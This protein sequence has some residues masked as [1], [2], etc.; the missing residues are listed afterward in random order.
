MDDNI[1]YRMLNFLDYKNLEEN[2]KI[3]AKKPK[4]KNK[5]IKEALMNAGPHIQNGNIKESEW[6]ST[7]SSITTVIEHYAAPHDDNIKERPLLAVFKNLS[8]NSKNIDINDK[9]GDNNPTIVV[10]L[11]DEK[12]IGEA[13]ERKLFISKSGKF[14]KN[15]KN[16]WK[17]TPGT[18]YAKRS[19][20]VLVLNEIPKENIINV[21]NPIA[22]DV[23]YAVAKYNEDMNNKSFSVIKFIE[24]ELPKL[25]EKE[26]YDISNG[27]SNTEYEL[28]DELYGNNKFLCDIVDDIYDKS[29]NLDVLEIYS[30]IKNQKRNI[31][32]ELLKILGY[33][34]HYVPIPEDSI[35]IIRKGECLEPQQ[36]YYTYKNKITYINFKEFNPDAKFELNH[37]SYAHLYDYH[38]GDELYALSSKEGIDVIT[39]DVDK[40]LSIDMQKM[41]FRS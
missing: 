15:N 26:S 22:M 1:T 35:L 4:D 25:Y 7:S 29:T 13:V 20:E 12:H 37:Y 38:N 33:N 8:E 17:P 30:S 19:K 16:G 5:I 6:I 39:N 24:E 27:L 32:D 18:K 9:I 23:V 2:G 21:L 10:N 40:K 31:I 28:F 34:L 14:F 11:S 36:D 41:K 3:I